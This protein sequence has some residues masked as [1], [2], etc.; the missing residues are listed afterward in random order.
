[1][2]DKDIYM[3][4]STSQDIQLRNRYLIDHACPTQVKLERL[5]RI[6]ALCLF[7]GAG[8]AL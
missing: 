7:T 6:V 1:M 8:G 2:R 5:L 3:L 4:K